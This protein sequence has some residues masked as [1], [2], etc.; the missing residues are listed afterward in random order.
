M[1]V[2]QIL[3]TDTLETGFRQKY[4]NS[5]NEIITGYKLLTDST[6]AYTA[7]VQLTKF[8]GGFIN[9][10]LSPE[11]YTKSQIGAII[12]SINSSPYSGTWVNVAYS[13]QA[14]VDHNGILWVSTSNTNTDEPGTSVKWIAVTYSAL[15]VRLFIASGASLPIPLASFQALYSAF[16]SIPKFTLRRITNNTDGSKTY[17]D[18]TASGTINITELID[19]IPDSISINV[20]DNGYGV[21][22]ADLQIIISK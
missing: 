10:D 11:F 1:A 14:I 16:G 9:I 19:G 8:G 3:S 20:L 21:T 7:V 4:N 17:Q 6:G 12:S 5:V 2:Q 13:A 22:S 15:P 18:L